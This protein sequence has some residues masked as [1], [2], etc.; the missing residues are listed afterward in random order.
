MWSA[1]HYWESGDIMDQITEFDMAILH[2]LHDKLSCGVMDFLMPLFTYLTEMG[3]VWLLS[4]LLFLMFRK[5]RG[6]AAIAGGLL[7]SLL[8]GNL[9]LKHLVARPRPC[10]IEPGFPMLVAVPQDFSFPSAHSMV[11]FAAA[12]VIFHYNRRFG[13][14]ALAVAAIIAFSRL[15]LFVHFPTD[16]LA[17]SLI[18]AGLGIAS[19]VV[20]DRLADRIAKNRASRE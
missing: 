10:W 16:V 1:F 5:Y 9:L 12:V 2:F 18:G 6:S 3:A 13:I 4:A 17:G 8:V 14:A 7:S 19:F 20:T 15:Y 11:S